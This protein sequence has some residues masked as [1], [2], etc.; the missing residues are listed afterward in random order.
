VD[1]HADAMALLGAI[2]HLEGVVALR[3]W[4]SYPPRD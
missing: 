1:R 2:R 4:L 3:D